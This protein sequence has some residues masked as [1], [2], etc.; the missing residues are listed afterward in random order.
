MDFL[1]SAG[2]KLYKRFL[3]DLMTRQKE[4]ALYTYTSLD[5]V[6]ESLRNPAIKVS[7]QE[8]EEILQSCMAVI[9]P[10]SHGLIAKTENCPVVLK[11]LLER[12]KAIFGEKISRVPM[13]VNIICPEKLSVNNDPLIIKLILMTLMG[14]AI[15]RTPRDGKVTIVAREQ[16]EEIQLEIQ[17]KGY[18]LPNEEKFFKD[19]F[20][21]FIREE[22][23][24]AF[25]QENGFF[26]D[27]SKA[28]GTI[29]TTTLVIPTAAPAL[30]FANV[31]PL[32]KE[33]T[34]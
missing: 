10:L 11:A 15:Y 14:K 31:T 19:V 21:P 7:V 1:Y 13:E 22:V 17:D 6:L 26:V 32:F 27:S 28:E 34:F 25:C 23:L 8:R 4:Q 3:A 16:E 33:A 29:H 12:V 2:N 5:V 30:S 20:M 9:K 18:V 24:Q